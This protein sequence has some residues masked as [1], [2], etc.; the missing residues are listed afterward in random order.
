M[1][2]ASSHARCRGPVRKDS[3]MRIYSL[4]TAGGLAPRLPITRR[5]VVL[6]EIDRPQ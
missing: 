4:I 2:P 5:G 6:R 3:A 1:E